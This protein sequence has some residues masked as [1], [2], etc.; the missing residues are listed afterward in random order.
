MMQ[1]RNTLKAYSG[2]TKTFH[3]LLG[4]SI[5]GL[6]AVGLSFDFMS[7]QLRSTVVPI[8]KSLGLTVL[9]FLSVWILKRLIEPHPAFPDSMP[10]WEKQAARI[11]HFLLYFLSFLMAFSGWMMSSAAGRPTVLWGWVDLSFPMTPDKALAGSFFLI[12]K[13]AAFILI[14][15]IIIHLAA[16]LKH[17]FIDRDT[18]L[19]RMLP[20][21]REEI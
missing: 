6:L 21:T 4:L 15:V 3:W 19:K 1:L 14:T 17:H 8:H 10:G 9:F 16:A 12:H 2:V 7:A 20:F 13:Y 11:S 5:I 18:I